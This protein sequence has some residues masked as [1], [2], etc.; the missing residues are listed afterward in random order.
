MSA[1]PSENNIE[2]DNFEHAYGDVELQ[3]TPCL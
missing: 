3:E 2:D 1:E